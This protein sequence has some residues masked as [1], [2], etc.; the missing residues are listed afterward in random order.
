VAASKVVSAQSIRSVKGIPAAMSYVVLALLFAHAALAQKAHFSGALAHLPGGGGYPY[1]LAVDGKGHIYIADTFRYVYG[2]NYPYG[3]AVDVQGN[4]YYTYTLLN[5]VVKQTLQPG[6]GYISSILPLTGLGGPE[7]I[8]VDS[9]GNVFIADASNNRILEATPSGDSYTQSV[10]P[11]QKLLLPES[12]AVD[13]SGNLFVADTYH[14]RIL[15]E[16]RTDTGW[17]ESILA[18]LDSAQGKLPISIAADNAGD[19]FILQTVG[20]GGSAVVLKETPSAG[21]YTQSVMPSYGQDPF[22]IAT[23]PYGNLY[24]NTPYMNS[25]TAGILEVLAGPTTMFPETGVASAS[26]KVS[27]VFTFDAP[28]TLGAPAVLTQGN[29]G[30]DFTNANTG[31]CGHKQATYLYNAGDSCFVDVVFNPKASGSRYGAVSLADTAGNPLAAAYVAGM[32]M[33]PQINF[34]PGQLLPVA[35]DLSDPAGVAVD[36]AGNIFVAESATGNVYKETVS[37]SS[38]GNSTFTRSGVASGL[39][40]PSALALDGAGNVYVLASGAVYKEAPSHGAYVQTQIPTDLPAL[41]GLAVDAGGNLYLASSTLGNIHKE[42]LQANGSYV[43]SSV[44]LGISPPSAV[45]VDGSGR[46]FISSPRDRA[47]FIETPQPNGSYLAASFDPGDPAPD[48]MTVDGAGNVY[49][50]NAGQ[51]EIYKFTQKLG[52]WVGTVARAGLITPSGVAVD[53][54]GNLYSV[55]GIGQLAIIDVSDP[56]SLGFPTTTTGAASSVTQ[57]VTNI[58]NDTLVFP[59]PATGTNATVTGTAFAFGSSTCPTI[60]PSNDAATLAPGDSCLY[61][62]TFTP[63]AGG[64]FFGLLSLIDNNLNATAPGAEQDI[65]LSGASFTPAGTR[66]TM[67]LSPSPVKEGL[68]VTVVVTVVDTDNSATAPQGSVVVLDTLGKQITSVGGRPLVLSN[69]KASI[70]FAPT[71]AGVHTVTARY[72]GVNGTFRASSS[73][74]SLTVQ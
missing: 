54:H 29:A 47:I 2:E 7:G 27:M 69:G 22:A 38:P 61:G 30:L 10:V 74:I 49:F 72:L 28:A 11:I 17:S 59:T 18:N 45:A 5:Q 31:T 71:G 65:P 1:G 53:G 36:A 16:T 13:G 63:P 15:K 12:V 14:Y 9:R 57:T 64:S 40:K 6:G 4:L 73:S 50:L 23:D 33:S 43:E 56:P 24:M 21:G 39:N 51:G 67:R 41:V 60:G 8:A 32:G 42:T 20:F 25:S 66:T 58:G 68:G 44:G 34:P 3:V 62:L 52:A 55:V 19:V 35:S 46:I 37:G 26:A 48:Y 70:S